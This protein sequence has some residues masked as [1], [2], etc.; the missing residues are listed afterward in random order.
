[1]E[2]TSTIITR[3][4]RHETD[5][6]RFDIE[7]SVADDRL[8]RIQ[9]NIFT[10]ATETDPEEKYRGNTYFDGREFSCNIPFTEDI[11]YYIEKALEVIRQ[12]TEEMTAEAASAL[13]ADDTTQNRNTP[14]R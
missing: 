4:A 3:M 12:I 10:P 7:Y 8:Q 11:P 9:M 14:S 13:L 2:I 6:A 1:M 5:R